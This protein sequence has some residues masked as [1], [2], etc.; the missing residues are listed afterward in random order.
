MILVLLK[1]EFVWERVKIVTFYIEKRGE[2]G[3][4]QLLLD[5]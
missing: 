4:V 3:R 5:A 2:R 1:W